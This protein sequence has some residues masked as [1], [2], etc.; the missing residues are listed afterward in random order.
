M[1]SQLVTMLSQLVPLLIV[2]A[3]IIAVFTVFVVI[4]VI[5]AH[6]RQISAGREELVGKT[7]EVLIAL[8]PR[9]CI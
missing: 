8:E 5:Q 3:I 4:W 9:Y 2:I 6:Q 7:A 1:L